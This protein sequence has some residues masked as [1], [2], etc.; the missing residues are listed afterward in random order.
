MRV[1][2]LPRYRGEGSKRDVTA[3]MTYK[4]NLTEIGMHDETLHSYYED[5]DLFQRMI[6][7]FFLKLF[8]ILLNRL[9]LDSMDSFISHTFHTQ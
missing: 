7:T 4:K 6:F 2:A 1:S 5:S 9:Q 3:W 8:P